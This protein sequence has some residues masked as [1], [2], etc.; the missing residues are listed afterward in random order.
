MFATGWTNMKT[1]ENSAFN[2][3]FG[4]KTDVVSFPD[5]TAPMR[6][7]AGAEGGHRA[8]SVVAVSL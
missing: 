8:S 4:G 7:P 3:V 6:R 2:F 1:L 5:T